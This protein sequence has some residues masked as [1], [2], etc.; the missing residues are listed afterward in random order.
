MSRCVLGPKKLKN[1]IQPLLPTNLKAIKAMV[2]GGNEHGLASVIA[3]TQGGGKAYGY[4]NYLTG[5]AWVDQEEYLKPEI[6]TP[7]T[8]EAI[9][10]DDDLRAVIRGSR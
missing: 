4:V 2:R 1:K 6:L 7:S 8:F 10:L 5:M 3:E 9:V